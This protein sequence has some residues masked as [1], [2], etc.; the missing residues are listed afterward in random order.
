MDYI[1][2]IQ[3][4]LRFY[5]VNERV[6]PDLLFF[7]GGGGFGSIILAEICLRVIDELLTGLVRNTISE[8]L[9]YRII[10]IS[11]VINSVHRIDLY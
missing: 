2:Y 1:S 8:E 11:S 10:D 6:H 9:I 4:E 3:L 7:F 5:S